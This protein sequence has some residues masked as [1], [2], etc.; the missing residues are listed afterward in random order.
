MLFLFA[1]WSSFINS[2]RLEPE[3]YHPKKKRP[4]FM[5]R[6][7]AERPGFEPGQRKTLTA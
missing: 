6:F 3:G 1:S 4:I 7:G 5:K 2:L